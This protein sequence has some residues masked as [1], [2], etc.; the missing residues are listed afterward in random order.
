MKAK[1]LLVDLAKNLHISP[2]ALT[3]VPTRLPSALI[4]LAV[5]GKCWASQAQRQPT[6][7]RATLAERYGVMFNT[8]IGF[9][10][11]RNGSQVPLFYGK[12]KTNNGLYHVFPRTGPANN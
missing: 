5:N 1:V 2:V 4:C 8:P 10:I 11:D 6:L 3:S 9:R 7:A 12:L